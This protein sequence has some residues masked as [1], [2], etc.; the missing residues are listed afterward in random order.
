MFKPASDQE[1]API[2]EPGFYLLTLEKLEE[3]APS[4]FSQDG[5]PQVKWF[6]TVSQ[7]GDPSAKV[8]MQN[9]EPYELY[10]WSSTSMNKRSKARPW[11]EA[12]LGRPLVVGEELKM[13]TIMFATMRA[14]VKH[15]K[16][17]DGTKTYCK[18]S[19]D[20]APTHVAKI[21]KNGAAKPPA[22]PAKTPSPAAASQSSAAPKPAFERRSLEKAWNKVV[23]RAELV[24][25]GSAEDW[26]AVNT[27]EL[28]DASLMEMTQ[29]AT[30]EVEALMKQPAA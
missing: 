23:A 17:Q 7:D 8:L 13:E 12:L 14:Y 22:T 24:N 26:A 4:Q 9:G 20:I 19:T 10:Q 29:A 2:I 25:H 15:E 6:F 30:H 18:I 5:A 1:S 11:A 28:D 21:T 16:S 27:D 3:A